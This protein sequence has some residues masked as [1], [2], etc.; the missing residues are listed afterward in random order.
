MFSNIYV[1]SSLFKES[2][3]HSFNWDFIAIF[4]LQI[5]ET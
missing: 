5:M 3:K 1:Y 2:V 4:I